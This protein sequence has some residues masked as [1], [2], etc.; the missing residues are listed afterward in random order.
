VHWR[1]QSALPVVGYGDF[2]NER[3]PDE[4]EI[5]DL[6]TGTK[7]KSENDLE[8]NTATKFYAACHERA[9]GR[10]TRHRRFLSLARN[11][12]P[13][14]A[15]IELLSDEPFSFDRIYSLAK[16]LTAAREN[17][18]YGAWENAQTCKSCTLTTH[19]TQTF[20]KR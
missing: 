3:G 16:M 1:D 17:G 20:G 13:K 4:D 9:T 19:C 11:K 10:K 5:V 6:K 8:Y 12:E 7:A 18:V 15:S 14:V 2:I